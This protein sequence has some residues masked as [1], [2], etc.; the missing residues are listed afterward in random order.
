MDREQAL[1]NMLLARQPREKK[2]PKPIAKMS[3]KTKAKKDEEKELRNGEDT[4][5]EQW[6]KARR[7]EIDIEVFVNQDN[8]VVFKQSDRILLSGD[9]K[10]WSALQKFILKE[11]GE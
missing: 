4:L 11:L 10:F 1:K 9:K 5:M 7:K 2:K 3:A 6:F 8:H